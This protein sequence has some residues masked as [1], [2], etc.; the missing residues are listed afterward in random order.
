MKDVVGFLPW[1]GL[2]VGV[3]A[4][5]LRGGSKGRIDWI[6]HVGLPVAVALASFVASTMADTDV[7]TALMFLAGGALAGSLVSVV[8][9]LAGTSEAGSVLAALGLTAFLAGVEAPG[10]ELHSIARLGGLVCGLGV[11]SLAFFSSATNRVGVT[12]A[13]MVFVA[14][15]LALI[16]QIGYSQSVQGGALLLAWSGLL[17]FGVLWSAGKPFKN[18]AV[19][20]VASV[21]VL[22]L[23]SW[24]V[25]SSYLGERQVG[26]VCVVAVVATLINAWAV[27]PD[28]HSVAAWGIAAVIWLGM[29]TYAFSTAFGLGM[30]AAGFV[31]VLTAFLLGRRDLLPAIGILVGLAVYRLFRENN[32]EL[33]Q[34]F[35]IGQH[36][37]MIGLLLGIV[38]LVAAVDAIQRRRSSRHLPFE[39]AIVGLIAATIVVGASAFFGTKG[40]IGLVVGLAIAPMVGQLGGARSQWAFAA[41]AVLQSAAL[42]A[43]RPLAFDTTLDRDA[44]TRLLLWL[45]VVTVAL[46]VALWL[47]GRP[48]REEKNA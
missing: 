32:E 14:G 27:P 28:R 7:R 40:A 2:F 18:K 46:Y 19:G 38:V 36:Y 39:A 42:V 3:V 16:A 48:K 30:A 26:T 13:S 15:A 12:L 45:V 20:P 47:L 1:I 43:Y 4:L 37:A 8:A 34:A 9:E 29:A 22:S 10:I 44:K 23:L 11:A 6:R 31:G 33:V 21:L 5:F 25:F 24:L 41:A 17:A 35:D